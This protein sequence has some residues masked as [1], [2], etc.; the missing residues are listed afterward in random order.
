MKSISESIKANEAIFNE[1]VAEFNR[2]E[3]RKTTLSENLVNTAGEETIELT[4]RITVLEDELYEIDRTL[5]QIGNYITTLKRKLR[6]D[7]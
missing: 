7:F 3:A 6:A 1:Y 2:L 4:K 5:I